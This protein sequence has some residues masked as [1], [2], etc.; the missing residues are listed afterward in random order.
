MTKK[1]IPT[2][3]EAGQPMMLPGLPGP[4]LDAGRHNADLTASMHRVIEG[5]TWKKQRTIMLLPSATMVPARAALAWMNLISPPNQPFVRWLLVGDEVGIAYSNAIEQILSHPDLSQWEYILT[6]EHDNLPPSDGLLK[7]IA[8]MEKHPELACV[9][10]LYWTKG[11]GGVPQIWGDP[12][13]PVLNFRP[14]PPRPGE[15]VECCGTGMGFNLFRISMFKDAKLR[16]PWFKTSAGAEG[17]GTQDLF[18][19]GDA[20]KYGYRCAIDCSVLV[21]H[22][23]L[24]TGVVW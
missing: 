4:S 2:S 9:G 19:W 22:L 13:D 18:F 14:Q 17:V 20:R 5:A 23:D 11:E 16:R 7:L 3:N 10:G 6:V 12:K 21:G 15:L 24:Q 8:Q 1:V